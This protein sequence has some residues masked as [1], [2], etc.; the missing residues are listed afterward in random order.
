M[1]IV[2]ENLM[3]LIRCIS[4]MVK[5]LKP[6]REDWR[7]FIAQ[8]F[9]DCFE[10]VIKENTGLISEKASQLSSE[11]RCADCIYGRKWI[12]EHAIKM[13]D[14]GHSIQDVFAF[15]RPRLKIIRVTPDENQLLRKYQNRNMTLEAYESVV[16][17]LFYL[18]HRGRKH[19]TRPATQEE[20]EKAFEA[21]K[22]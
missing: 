22:E 5:E 6:V 1:S 3:D 13:L 12:F 9:Y 7:S 2:D 17:K 14:G 21:S 16:G 20:K 19:Q 18:K 15:V 11:S 4:A 8:H 10:K